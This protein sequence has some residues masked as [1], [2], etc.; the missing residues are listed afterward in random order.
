MV[1]ITLALM[2]AMRLTPKVDIFSNQNVNFREFYMAFQE[3]TGSKTSS[4]LSGK[5]NKL[6]VD[7]G[8]QPMERQFFSL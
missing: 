2:G 8:F 3:S 6:T 7:K 4:R 5:A 1:F